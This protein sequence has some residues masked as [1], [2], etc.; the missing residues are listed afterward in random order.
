MIPLPHTTDRFLAAAPSWDAF[1]RKASALPASA[2]G[3]A[4]DKG[5]VFERLTQLYLKTHPDYQ[6]RLRNIWRVKDELPPAIRKRIGL[7]RSDEGIDL[8]A[9]TFDGD[10]WAIQCKFRTE[11]RQPLTVTDLATF[12]SLSFD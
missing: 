10:I 8:V 11:T 4:P 7:P 12:A 6:T 3:P 1:F 5:K 2:P 9:E